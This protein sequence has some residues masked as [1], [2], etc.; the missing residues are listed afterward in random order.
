MT[1]SVHGRRVA[2]IVRVA[3]VARDMKVSD[4][5]DEGGGCVV[6]VVVLEP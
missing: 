2:I 6:V 1:S 4:V 5:G 3:C